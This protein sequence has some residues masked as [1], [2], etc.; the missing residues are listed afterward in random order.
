MSYLIDYIRSVYWDLGKDTKLMT[1]PQDGIPV[2]ILMIK[3]FTRFRD[4]ILQHAK[5]TRFEELTL[6][7]LLSFMGKKGYANGIGAMSAEARMVASK[8]D[9]R[10]GSEWWRRVKRDPTT[11]KWASC[12]RRTTMS[13]NDMWKFRR[14]EPHYI[15]SKVISWAIHMLVVWMPRFGRRMQRMKREPYGVNEVWDLLIVLRKRGMYEEFIQTLEGS[16]IIHL[17]ILPQTFEIICQ[18]K[19]FILFVSAC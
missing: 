7:H 10:M 1:L 4:D 3:Y 8:R 2:H 9:T 14:E 17:R 5:S 16:I 13:S 11:T 15:L 12:G 19:L 6:F 18:L